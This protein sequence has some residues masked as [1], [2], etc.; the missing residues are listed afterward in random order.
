MI[1]RMTTEVKILTGIIVVTV[2]LI[3]G[4]VFFLSKPE[5]AVMVDAATLVKDDSLKQSSESAKLT[6][7]EFGDMQCPACKLAHPGLKQAIADFPGQ[8][9]F[10]FR[11]YPLPQHK[12]AI[13]GAKAVEAANM[14]GK[15]WEM[16]DKLYDSQEEWAESD[17]PVEIFKKY[18]T[19]LGMDAEK[20][21]SDMSLPAI[22]DKITK[23]QGDGN[24]VGVNSTP[25]LYFNNELYKKGVG[26]SDFKAEIEARLK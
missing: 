14:Q 18:A 13:A 19:D 24:A 25:T 6:I 15:V 2:A 23:D 20:L 3:I 7:V 17:N 21:A 4:A 9:N 11:H 1:N 10:V 8:V 12:N 16:F 22:Q 5:K 26:Y